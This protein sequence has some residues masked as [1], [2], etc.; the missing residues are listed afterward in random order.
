VLRQENAWWKIH[1]DRKVPTNDND[2]TIR[3]LFHVEETSSKDR[4]KTIVVDD[5][6][7]DKDNNENKIKQGDDHKLRL[8]KILDQRDFHMESS[9][10]ATEL[11]F[12]FCNGQKCVRNLWLIQSSDFVVAAIPTGHLLKSSQ[13]YCHSHIFHAISHVVA[14]TTH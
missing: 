4:S 12:R 8:E 5:S 1:N 10:L 13:H 11:D 6:K 7:N 2:E 3:R 9:T 14:I